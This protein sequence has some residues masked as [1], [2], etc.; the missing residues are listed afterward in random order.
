MCAREGLKY[1][2]DGLRLVEIRLRGPDAAELHQ[3]T[4]LAVSFRQRVED[5]KHLGLAVIQSTAGLWV[6]GENDFEHGVLLVIKGRTP[7]CREMSA[8]M[9]CLKCQLRMATYFS[10]VLKKNRPRTRSHLRSISARTTLLLML[11]AIP[12]RERRHNLLR[13]NQ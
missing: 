13:C 11:A 2:R 3:V 7:P 1:R 12:L 9:G 4:Q 10:D 8:P 6:N 5:A